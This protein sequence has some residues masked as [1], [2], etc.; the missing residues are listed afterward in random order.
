[1]NVL[2]RTEKDYLLAILVLILRITNRISEIIGMKCGGDRHESLVSLIGGVVEY[3]YNEVWTQQIKILENWLTEHNAEL[4]ATK[5]KK[6][7]RSC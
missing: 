7:C 6:H 4:E 1:V 2:T 3:E 5:V